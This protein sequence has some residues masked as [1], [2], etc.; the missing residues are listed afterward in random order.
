ML[1]GSILIFQF[2]EFLLIPSQ[3]IDFLLEVGDDN[4]L[5]VG[6]D[7]ERGVEIGRTF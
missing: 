3:Q 2:D 4:F 5:L 6:L 1:E 7:L